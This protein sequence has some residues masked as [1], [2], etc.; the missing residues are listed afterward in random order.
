MMVTDDL[1]F[2]YPGYSQG[3]TDVKTPTMD[4][5]A[6]EEGVILNA[7]YMY[8]YCSPSRGSLLSGRYPWKLS[9][10]RCNLIPSSIPEGVDLTY[11]FLPLHLRKAGYRS[12]HIG[13]WHLGFFE[14]AYTPVARGFDSSFGFLEGGEDHWTHRCGAGKLNCQVDGLGEQY[15]DLWEQ[16]TTNFPGNIALG[17]NGTTGDEQTY[18]GY[19]F[20]KRVVDEIE[21]HGNEFSNRPLFLYF[22]MHNTHA[23]IEAPKRF[24]DMYSNIEDEK[25]RTFLAMVSV[26]DESVQNVSSALRRNG[27]W[28]DTLFVWT[29]DNGSPIQVAG[30]NWPLRGGKGTNF[31]GGVR[32]PGFLAGGA[33][34]TR[35]YGKV[36]NGLVSVSDWYAT[37]SELAGLGSTIPVAGPSKSDSISMLKY[38]WGETP[39]SPRTILV[40]DHHMF[41]NESARDGCAGQSPF[42]MP[43]YDALGAIRMGNYKLIVGQEHFASWYGH[44]SPNATI[45]PDLGA[46]ACVSHPCLFDIVRDPGEH[47]DVSSTMPGMVEK[48]WRAFNESN[49]DHHPLVV[50]PKQDMD[51][52]CAMIRTN[53][54]WISPWISKKRS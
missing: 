51:G 18:S 5:L 46:V 15:F 9:S 4:R 11:E 10:S 45:A 37:F 29:T 35:M 13:K 34:P 44:F 25:E 39:S 40:H 24:V 43:G 8:K 14:D 38:F 6:K 17:M 30:S 48:L 41:T 28:N 19:I 12:V 21:R 22:A 50:P 33:I 54:G 32:V 2:N 1:G 27:M 26:V 49:R 31:E 47:N 20:T 42:S 53:D 16:N 52:F 36:L 3:N 23:P 7:S